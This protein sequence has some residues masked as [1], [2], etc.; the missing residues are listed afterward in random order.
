MTKI[1]YF[2]FVLTLIVACKGKTASDEESNEAISQTPENVK[3]ES[4]IEKR[5]AFTDLQENLEVVNSLYFTKD[6]GSSLDVKAFL[7]K[8]QTIVKVEERYVDKNIDTYGTT[9]FYIHNGKKYASKE[10]F[11]E[12]SEGKVYFVE[13]VSF[14]DAKEK[15]INSKIRKAD[16]EEELDSKIFEQIAKVDCPIKR[17]MDA[18][19]QEGDFETRFQGFVVSGRDTYITVGKT[20]DGYISAL[21]MQYKTP[22]TNKLEK[23]QAQSIGKKLDIEFQK[24]V[25]E[26]DFEFQ[27]LL[28]V[29][30][31]K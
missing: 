18:I 21:L 22:F 6:D 2:A 20:P 26:T 29:N 3:A 24:M 9:I 17:A 16:F 11:E 27:V 10:R 14:Y 30:E 28:S 15:V 19:N 13:R 5:I 12:K 4:E 31:A 8:S 7:D 25:D 1:L 23:N